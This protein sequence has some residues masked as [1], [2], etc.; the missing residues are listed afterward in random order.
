M[1]DSIYTSSVDIPKNMNHALMRGEAVKYQGVSFL[2]DEMVITSQ[3]YYANED[4]IVS[5]FCEI[6]IP[7]YQPNLN[8][9]TLLLEL[10]ALHNILKP[11]S[12]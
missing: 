11:R 9:Y 7:S 3:C 10:L 12:H 2:N 4:E 8:T 6:W 5:T 1:I